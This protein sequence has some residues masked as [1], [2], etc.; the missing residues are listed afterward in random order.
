SPANVSMGRRSG[1]AVVTEQYAP[2]SSVLVDVEWNVLNGVAPP[3]AQLFPHFADG[4]E[5]QTDFLLTNPNSVPVTAELRFH[6]D[7][8]SLGLNIQ[9]MGVTSSIPGITIQ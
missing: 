9:G 2:D 1:I 8:S 7:G 6:V 3:P 4:G 5:W